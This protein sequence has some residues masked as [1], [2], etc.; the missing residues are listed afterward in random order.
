MGQSTGI[1]VIANFAPQLFAG[2]GYSNVL[3]LGLSAAWV[4]VCAVGTWLSGL[5]I[6]RIGRVKQLSKWKADR[7]TVLS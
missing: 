4:T 1:V 7:D 3:Q 5:L 6:E 2:L